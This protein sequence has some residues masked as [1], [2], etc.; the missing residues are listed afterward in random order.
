MAS[1][2]EVRGTESIRD[3]GRLL[4][5]APKE[6][7]RD[8]LREFR[9]AGTPTRKAV[10][11][12]LSEDLPQGGGAAKTISRVKVGVRNSLT[13]RNAGVRFSVAHGKNDITAIERGV[14]RHPI[15]GNRDRWAITKVPSGIV[16]A[17]VETQR[18]AMAAAV[19][20]AIDST[21]DKIARG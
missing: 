21:L 18:P 3:L 2:L 7:R 5:A 11:A 14:L 6:L 16:G 17:A 20:A 8:M 10:Q 12:A 13:G 1:A 4:K 19:V 15:Y 9:A